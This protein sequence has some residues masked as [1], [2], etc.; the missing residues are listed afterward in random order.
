MDVQR[1]LMNLRRILLVCLLPG[2]STVAVAG[3]MS[4]WIDFKGCEDSDV[5]NDRCSKLAVP[6]NRADPSDRVIG[7]HV[8]VAPAVGTE[9]VADPICF[10]YGGPGAMR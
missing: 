4:G 8:V 7:I 9:V 6:G 10:F 3:S 5:E 2:S 1:S